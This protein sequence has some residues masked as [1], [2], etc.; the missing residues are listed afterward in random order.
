MFVNSISIRR[1]GYYGGGYGSRAD[2]TKPFNATIEVQG[3]H[4]KVELTL[5]PDMSQRIVAIISE[6]VAAAGRATAEAMTASCLTALPAPV[7]AEANG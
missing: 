2:Q 3:Q 1:E 6:E 5:S 7:E 4:G